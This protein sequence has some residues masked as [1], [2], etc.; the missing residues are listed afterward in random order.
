MGRGLAF[1]GA[2][3]GPTSDLYVY[4]LRDGSISQLTNG[5]SQG[6]EP[7]WSPDGR[8][9]V[10][11]GVSTLGT[12]AGYGMVGVWAAAADGSDVKSL[13]TPDSSGEQWVMWTGPETLML[14]SWSPA[15][16]AYNL[17]TLDIASGNV[18]VLFDHPFDQVAADAASGTALLTV[19][20]YTAESMPGGQTGAF[21]VSTDGGVQQVITANSF[22]PTWSAG[23]GDYY[24]LVSDI[25]T[26][27]VSTSG[28]AQP[29][30]APLRDFPDV[31]PGAAYWA[32]FSKD[33]TA[34]GLWV[35][36]F[37]QAPT[38]VYQFPLSA[39]QWSPDG[40]RLFAFD[41]DTLYMGTAPDFNLQAL[42]SGLHVSSLRA[43]WI[44]GQ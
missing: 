3:Q 14:Y 19:Q 16:G 9:I 38:K 11:A 24:A 43:A 25:G 12:G 36:P 15:Y 1:M 22:A 42:Q 37:G 34:G 35:G 20:H 4:D 32:W 30:P 7:T 40:S 28:A 2:M 26:Y 6:I 39:T 10:H 27:Q 17:R 31:S 8:Y 44:G 33:L 29:V 5:A 18:N 21:L 23:A 13:F 41:T